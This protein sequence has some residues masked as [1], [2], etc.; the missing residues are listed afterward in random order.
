MVVEADEYDHSFLWVRPAVAIVTNIDFDHPDIFPDQAAYDRAFRRFLAGVPADGTVVVNADDAGTSRV[1]ADSTGIVA[2]LVRVGHS[3]K[4]DWRVEG[5]ALSPPSGERIALD[6]QVAGAHNRLNAAMAIAA[7]DAVGIDSDAAARGIGTFT[8]VGRRFELKGK[9][10]GV[11]VVDDYAHHPV[12]IVATLAAARGRYPGRRLWAVFQPHTY[13]RTKLLLDD[14]AR[15][16]DGA[17]EVVLLDVY[18]ARETDTLDVSSAPSSA[19]AKSP[20]RS[21]VR[22]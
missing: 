7:L 12:E 3:D 1:L 13:S 8:G 10:A 16:L 18:P 22:L 6:L 19:R 20:R 15:A 21:L 2:R 4:A 9:A 5:D 14:F 17:D 11:T